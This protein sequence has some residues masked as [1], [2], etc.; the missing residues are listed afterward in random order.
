MTQALQ[1]LRADPPGIVISDAEAGMSALSR[2]DC[3]AVIMRRSVAVGGLSWID[4]LDPGVLPRGAGTF[5]PG[6]VAGT[7][8]QFYDA[9]GTPAGPERTWFTRDVASL[10]RDFAALMGVSFLRLRLDVIRGDACRRFHVDAVRARLICTYRGPGT[11]YGV[12][13]PGAEPDRVFSVPR[14]LPMLLRGSL[15]PSR[16][17]LRVLH[18]SPPIEGLGKVRL[19]LV[20]DP[21]FDREDETDL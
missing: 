18:R 4:A 16:A 20:L 1:R 6:A 2:P 19:V 11:Q 7:L 8:E 14:G 5:R 17:A 9:C 15:W 12:A 21:V 10:G 13:R 3:G